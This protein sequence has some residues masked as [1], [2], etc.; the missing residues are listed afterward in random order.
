L[1]SGKAYQKF[2]EIIEAQQGKIK[3]LKPA[4]FS[5]PAKA[6]KTGKIMQIDNKKIS[7]IAKAAG[8]PSDKES[9][10]YLNVHIND[11]VKKNQVLMTIYAETK[12][13]LKFAK[14]TYSRENPFVIS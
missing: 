8:C 14:E 1:K 3:N 4:K 9:G 11:K 7:S 12:D 10:I 5:F 2:K 6:S 13:K